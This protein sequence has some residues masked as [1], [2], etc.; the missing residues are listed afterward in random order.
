MPTLTGAVTNLIQG[1]SQQDPK[2]RSMGQ[3]SEQVNM[4]SS[5]S[6]G[7]VK[8]P[9]TK[10][11]FQIPASITIDHDTQ[12][13]EYTS[14]DDAYIVFIRPDGMAVLDYD[15]NFQPISGG[16]DSYTAEFKDPAI[17]SSHNLSDYMD[18]VNPLSGAEDIKAYT[19][20]D[21]TFVLNKKK[22]VEK[23]SLS[24]YTPYEYSYVYVKS[25]SFGL[26]YTIFEDVAGSLVTR[27]SVTI[28][29]TKTVASGSVNLQT[30]PS[31]KDVACY[32][33]DQLIA[34]GLTSSYLIGDSVIASQAVLVA[35][36]DLGGDDI[37]AYTNSIPRYDM[38]PLMGDSIQD[39][40][41]VA[42]DSENSYFVKGSGEASVSATISYTDPV[43]GSPVTSTA[44][45]I[46]Y[47]DFRWDEVA[48]D[49]VVNELDSKTMPH[50]LKKTASG[51]LFT[52]GDWEDRPAGDTDTNPDPKFVG[53]TI[54][55]IGAYQ[56][57]LVMLSGKY[58]CA[59]R[60]DE[61]F[62]FWKDTVIRPNPANPCYIAVGGTSASGGE[63]LKALSVVAGDLLVYS[64]TTQYRLYG[65]NEF[66]ASSPIVA[67][68]SVVSS[69]AAA[70]VN[71]DVGVLLAVSSG[72]F[73]NVRDLVVLGNS[74]LIEPV[75]L[76]DHCPYYIEDTPV[77]ILMHTTHNIGFVRTKDGFAPS[78]ALWVYEAGKNTAGE[79]IQLA[80]HKWVFGDLD[81]P[82]LLYN[83]W[84]KDDDLYIIIRHIDDGTKT[85]LYTLP[86]SID[87]T[88]FL[89]FRPHLDRMQEVT[90]EATNPSEADI[91]AGDDIECILTDD[92]SGI[93]L[94]AT[95][96][97]DR[98]TIDPEEA[99]DV[100]TKV[101]VGKPFTAYIDP[102]TLF[103]RRQDGSVRTTNR[104]QLLRMWLD[105]T[106][107]AYIK[108]TV[109]DKTGRVTYVDWDSNEDAINAIW[110]EI[111][112]QSGTLTVPLR[113]T[114]NG[115]HIRIETNDY[116]PFGVTGFTFRARYGSRA[117]ARAKNTVIT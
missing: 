22:V 105:Y 65:E 82:D 5:T 1:V 64:N 51:L 112:L 15:G 9:G 97:G 14:G 45:H 94:K 92:G 56:N 54:S 114:N 16:Y 8:R 66:T 25:V 24:P 29:S 106:N 31:A 34:A 47:S 116:R 59:S 110:D 89:D 86:L 17:T 48:D 117:N 68:S 62:A 111:T 91:L 27:A 108:V 88:E 102:G 73:T 78:R 83:M 33:L 19:I 4:R 37:I 21:T 109:T 11:K 39:I 18:N 13:H 10:L 100:P 28:P 6:R 80:W 87:T 72:A 74:R 107:T 58:V 20:A 70:P 7:V 96:S 84:I 26:T 43:T 93:Q 79:R 90:T 69:L 30:V 38:L 3:V 75:G 44:D 103:L 104:T 12:V 42:D 2:I 85:M 61:W 60:T 40:E 52:L 46:M 35:E 50:V 71:S 53:K 77:Q 98:L 95:S 63:D 23:G 32:L 57:R 76:T 67:V 113:G 49:A 101:L 115:L 36:D 41:V 81:N 99:V 55:D